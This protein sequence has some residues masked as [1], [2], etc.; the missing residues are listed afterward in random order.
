MK[1]KKLSA[2]S[3]IELSIVI[4]IIGIMI[5]GVVS[6][7]RLVG[8]YR[9]TSARNTS[10]SSSIASI[11]GLVLWLDVTAP[12]RVKNT[13]DADAV[14]GDR[15]KTWTDNSPQINPQ[16]AFTQI[17][18]GKGP[19]YKNEGINNLPTMHFRGDADTASEA[20]SGPVAGCLSTPYNASLNSSTFTMFV[21]Y[22]SLLEVNSGKFG[23]IFASNG[24]N[25]GTSFGKIPS[26]I[27]FGSGTGSAVTAT[28]NTVNINQAYIG[29]LVRNST[30]STLYLNGTSVDSDTAD[31]SINSS[32]SS[33]VGCGAVDST[34]ADYFNGYVSEIIIYERELKAEERKSVEKYLSKKYAIA[35]S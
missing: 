30:A 26:N 22:N 32:S 4:L 24:S 35:V 18:T 20:S 6:A 31:Y 29:T 13:S 8:E 16:V 2:F 34:A 7:S 25:T 5:A 17:A 3:F 10:V 21:V 15:V 27:R 11:T 14:D 23:S 1:N 33:S 19:L 28:Q 9:L 12:N